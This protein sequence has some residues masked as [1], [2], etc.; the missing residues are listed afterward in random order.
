[1]NDHTGGAEEFA[2]THPELAAELERAVT[3][4]PPH[5]TGARRA[6]IE[7]AIGSV[8]MTA[9]V[10]LVLL[11]GRLA[12]DWGSWSLVALGVIGT[13]LAGGVAH[14]WA[15]LTGRVTVIE[16]ITGLGGCERP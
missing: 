11:I 1:M 2:R 15:H 12:G 9:L 13:V 8:A 7:E 14:L 6:A 4:E 5:I 16:D 10:F 3:A